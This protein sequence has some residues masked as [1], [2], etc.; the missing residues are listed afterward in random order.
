MAGKGRA[1][2]K[3]GRDIAQRQEFARMGVDEHLV[4]LGEHRRGYARREVGK[5]VAAGPR[6]WRVARVER[7][8]VATRS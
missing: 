8:V 5:R 4:L 7:T 6:R 3:I 2:G 1:L